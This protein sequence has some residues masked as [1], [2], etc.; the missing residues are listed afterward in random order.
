[1]ACRTVCAWAFVAWLVASFGAIGCARDHGT[2]DPALRPATPRIARDQMRYALQMGTRYLIQRQQADGS[3]RSDRYA[4]F[5]DGTALT[6]LVLTA[7][8]A[9]WDSGDTEPELAQTI[10]AGCAFMLQFSDPRGSLRI[11][12]D[13]LEYPV[14]TAAL[15]VQVFSHARAG[16][17]AAARQAWVQYLKERQLVETHGWQRGDKEYGGWGYCRLIPR[18]PAPGELAPALLESNLSATVH[19]V[20]ALAEAGSLDAATAQAALVFIRRRHNWSPIVQGPGNDGGFHFIYDDPVRNKAGSTWVAEGPYL[21]DESLRPLWYFSYGSATA[22]GLRAL[23]LCGERDSQRIEAARA[24]LREHF[25]ADR[26]PG[27]YPPIREYQRDAVYYYYT[28]SVARA[29][30]LAHIQLADGRSWASELAA[31]LV[32]RQQADGSWQNAHDL[33]RED[34]PLVATAL[35]LTA[36]SHCHRT[37][38]SPR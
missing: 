11:A 31:A 22:D 28:A 12:E 26:H 24:W 32:T 1:M 5:R 36:L 34:E 16:Q 19:A 15:T 25:R 10:R 7:M 20:Q 38:F 2:A 13:Q 35:A 33:V 3:W 18:K 30:Q 4:P 27:Y 29:M 8:Q 17:A 9:A 21:P 14:Y 23:L 37:L 6:P